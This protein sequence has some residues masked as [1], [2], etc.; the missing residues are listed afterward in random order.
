MFTLTQPKVNLWIISTK[1]EDGKDFGRCATRGGEYLR[2]FCGMSFF[3][4]CIRF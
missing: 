3:I 1:D 2:V 4:V